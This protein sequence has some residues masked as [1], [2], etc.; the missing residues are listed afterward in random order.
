MPRDAAILLDML[1]SARRALEYVR[2]K[3][4]NEF[5]ADGALQDMVVRRL[6][7]VGEAAVRV[8]QETRDSLPGIPWRKV[9]GL[10]N[11]LIHQYFRLDLDRV[12]EVLQDDLP[13]LIAALEPV[14]PPPGTSQATGT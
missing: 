11:V 10:R 4:Q 2:G 14:V 9:V 8:S 13:K 3:T 12:W 6:E 1:I 5:L 7:I